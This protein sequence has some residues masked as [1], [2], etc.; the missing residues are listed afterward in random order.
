MFK[1]KKKTI[2]LFLDKKKIG[3]FPNKC[4][5]N[6]NRG[7]L[8]LFLGILRVAESKKNRAP[9]SV[10]KG[11]SIQLESFES[12]TMLHLKLFYQNFSIFKKMQNR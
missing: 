8:T 11:Q 5:T 1:K 3:D 6:I 10:H 2:L 12:S 9:F 4:Y 7:Y